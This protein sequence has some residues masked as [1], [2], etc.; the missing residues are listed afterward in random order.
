LPPVLVAVINQNKYFMYPPIKKHKGE[1]KTFKQ[2]LTLV[3]GNELS[4]LDCLIG[5][6]KNNIYDFR[7][8]SDFLPDSFSKEILKLETAINTENQKRYENYENYYENY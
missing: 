3:S 1:V 4:E 8:V 6:I 7:H 5:K 2:C